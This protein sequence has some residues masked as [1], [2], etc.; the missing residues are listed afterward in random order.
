MQNLSGDVWIKE[1]KCWLEKISRPVYVV[2]VLVD[3]ELQQ[4][5]KLIKTESPKT[6]K[7]KLNPNKIT[8]YDIDQLC[9]VAHFEL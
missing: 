1:G 3:L 6:V 5:L 7:K 8:L 4:S 9:K 2:D